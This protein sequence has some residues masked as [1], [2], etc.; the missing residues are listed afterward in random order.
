MAVSITLNHT[1]KKT[2]KGT[3]SMQLDVVAFGISSKVFAI[4]VFPKSAD[5]QAPNC[6]FSHVCSPSE[7]IEFPEDEP[8]DACYFRTDSV[9]FI[10]DNDL[11]IDHVLNNVNGDLD[12]LVKEFNAIE[13]DSVVIEGTDTFE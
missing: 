12:N 7:L 5:S 1:I 13:S 10:F 8:G 2:P 3:V 9:E 4:E 11:V 6:R